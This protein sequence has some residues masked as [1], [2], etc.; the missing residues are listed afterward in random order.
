V[1]TAKR[2]TKRP[3]KSPAKR[4][5]KSVAKSPAKKSVSKPIAPPLKQDG[6]RRLRSPTYKS[7]HL[8][9]RIKHP[10]KLPSAWRLTKMTTRLL[11]GHK[12]LFIGITLIYAILNLV[13]VQGLSNT[14]DITSLKATLQDAFGTGSAF[15]ASL[16][17]FAV[18]ISSSGSSAS[19]TGG[20]YQLFLI[21]LVSLAVIWALRE[22]L[23]GVRIRVRD[24]YYRGMYPLV[25]FILVLVVIGIQLIPLVLGA[26]IYNIVISNGIAVIAAEKVL[27]AIL[28]GLLS[29]LSIYMISSSVFALYIVTLP[30]MTPLK[31]LR[32][33]RALVRFRRW[34]VLRKILLLPLILLII[35]TV[36][37]LPIILVATPVAQ[38]TFY[39]LTMFAVVVTHTYLYS[40]YRELLHEQN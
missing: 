17:V 30:D 22:L 4:P 12:R 11:W 10:V 20:A 28:F 31:A 21:I 38:W 16:T 25:P 2:A 15:T 37:M 3:L 33:A 7:L 32:S 40:L 1:A 34:T 14:T 13:L 36:I 9:K 18:L 23:A 8:S 29:L 6:P 27:W 26:T 35:T 19:G 39:L 5:S 24:A